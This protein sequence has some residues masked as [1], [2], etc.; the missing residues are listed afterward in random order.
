MHPSDFDA[1]AILLHPEDEVAVARAAIPA[2]T[3]LR[4]GESVLVVRSDIPSGHKIAR[5]AVPA[6]APVRRYG[7]PIGLA[8]SR[9]EPG[10][11]VHTHNLTTKGMEGTVGVAA[12][13]SWTHRSVG[14]GRAEPAAPSRS[15]LGF[16][17]ADGRVG[18]RNHVA[19]ISTVNCSAAVCRFV[20]ERFRDVRADYPNVDSVTALTHEGGCGGTVGSDDHKTLM[21]V[22]GGYARHANVAGCV[23]VGLGCE[24]N[25]V[26]TLV[27]DQGLQRVPSFIIQ[28]EGGTRRTV[29]AVS[30]A[31]RKLLPRANEA[32]RTPQQASDLVLATNCGGSD[33][34][35]GVTA[36]PA[37]GWAVDELVRWGGA[38]LLGETTEIFGAEQLLASRAVSPQVAS[39]LLERV[40]WWK[41]WLMR[42]GSTIDANPAPGNI[43]AGLTTVFEKSLG[44]ISKGGTS[45]L[46]DVIPYA[47]EVRGSGLIY[48][49]TPGYD[50]VSVT[51]MVAGGANVVA[52]TTG[53]G[54]V[55]GSAIAPSLKLATTTDLYRRMEPDMD[56]DCGVILDGTPLAS[57][58]AA[59]FDRILAVAS[60]ERTKSEEQ[61]LGED[62]F[63]PWIRGPVT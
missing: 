47:G 26:S 3:R 16:R 63:V 12:P 51:G 53:C 20:R 15:F 44:G 45:P 14:S 29:D 48:M 32:R 57:V 60:G 19:V 40:R 52:F 11:H 2:G 7:Q 9:I 46:V 27:A 1:L 33:S 6:G 50:P 31:V 36:N 18:T 54:S 24:K 4:I 10:D 42:L 13:D 56:V 23:L 58:G 25:K 62:E 61:G 59:I 34:W 37:L 28:Q 43:A 55:F 17:R 5:H 21:R 38:A 30:D 8:S 39:R 41:E 35:S 49:D 22:L